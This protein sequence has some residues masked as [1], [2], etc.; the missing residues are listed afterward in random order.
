MHAVPRLNVSENA[1]SCFEIIS[2]FADKFKR[3]A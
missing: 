2:G 1:P 3:I